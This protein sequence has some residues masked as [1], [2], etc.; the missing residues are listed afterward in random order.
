[1]TPLTN[2]RECPH[3]DPRKAPL[4]MRADSLLRSSRRRSRTS[5]ASRPKRTD[6]SLGRVADRQPLLGDG[7]QTLQATLSELPSS[8]YQGEHYPVPYPQ[9]LGRSP[10]HMSVLGHARSDRIPWSPSGIRM[11]VR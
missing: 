7:G 9:V 11:T 1:M 5:T 2:G 4:A 3:D 10:G 8:V 6:A